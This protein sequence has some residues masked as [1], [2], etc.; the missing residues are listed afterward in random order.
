MQGRLPGQI[1]FAGGQAGSVL[2]PQR[3]A[4]PGVDPHRAA[5]AA[6]AAHLAGQQERDGIG[7]PGRLGQADALEGA[8]GQGGLGGGHRL[9]RGQGRLAGARLDPGRLVRVQGGEPAHYRLH[10][11]GPGHV[12]AGDG[13]D[14]Q[15][16]QGVDAGGAVQVEQQAA[17]S[18]ATLDRQGEA[19]LAPAR[20]PQ[21]EADQGGEGPGQGGA[22]H[23][24]QA[25][26]AEQQLAVQ[27]VDEVQQAGP[28]DL[29][30]AALP[31]AQFAAGVGVEQGLEPVEAPR[32]VGPGLLQPYRRGVA[33]AGRRGDGYRLVAGVVAPGGV[34]QLGQG[35]GDGVFP[36]R[37]GGEQFRVEQPV[38]FRGEDQEAAGDGGEAHQAGQGQPGVTVQQ[39]AQAADAHGIGDSG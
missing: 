39:G 28:A 12:H 2:D 22:G 24:P 18:G 14:E 20:P 36:G 37:G 35:A 4:A 17:R 1:G 8:L 19:Q 29:D 15:H 31:G 33:G 38:Q 7:V 6:G 16:G 21:V 13:Q 9:V 11:G 10:G 5:A 25:G 30:A 3:V 26:L 23:Q 27:V 32:L 34:E